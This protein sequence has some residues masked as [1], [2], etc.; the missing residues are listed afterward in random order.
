MTTQHLPDVTAVT[1]EAR[2]IATITVAFSIDPLT[3]WLLPDARQYLTHWHPLVQAFAGEAFTHGSADSI[4][5]GGGVALWL[6]PGVEADEEVITA[7]ATEAIAQDDR[8]EIFAV[9]GQT[10]AFHPAEPHWYLPVIGVDITRRGRAYG[11]ALLRHGLDR[12]DR[13]G[14]PAYLEAS[15]SRSKALYERHGF[16]EVGV[17]QGGTS[18]PMWPMVRPPAGGG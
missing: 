7:L 8:E 9:M 12:C 11:S 4:D 6:P 1:D 2:A 5:D 16:E 17:I 14:V 13:D 3:R 15:T 18:P 10:A